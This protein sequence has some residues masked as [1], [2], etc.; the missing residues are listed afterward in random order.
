MTPLQLDATVMPDGML[1]VSLPTQWRSRKVRVVVE[2]KVPD[3]ES[4]G[5]SDD[6]CLPGK[7]PPELYGSIWEIEGADIVSP[8]DVQWEAMR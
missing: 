4:R 2:E 3:N 7:V 5:E 1:A 8:I 6:N